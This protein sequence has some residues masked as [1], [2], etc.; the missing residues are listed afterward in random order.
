MQIDVKQDFRF[1]AV[2]LQALQEAAETYLTCLFE[3]SYLAAIH[4]KRVT[5]F[6]SDVQLVRR[7]RG[8]HLT[9]C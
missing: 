7:L 4:A 5:L 1:Q 2:A 6:R 8:E 3:D 9:M